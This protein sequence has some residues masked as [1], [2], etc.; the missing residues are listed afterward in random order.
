QRNTRREHEREAAKQPWLGILRELGNR[1]IAQTD[2]EQ[3]EVD[4]QY[5]SRGH[6]EPDEMEGFDQGKQPD[7][8]ANGIANS[9]PLT[10][11]KQLQERHQYSDSCGMQLV[12]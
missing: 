9:G 4:Q 2:A 8:L 1:M 11:L 7:R 3:A 6:S 10:P 12:R 5:G